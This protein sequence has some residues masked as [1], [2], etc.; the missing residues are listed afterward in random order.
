MR[1]LL[2]TN[3]L[4]QWGA[5]YC[6]DRG[7]DDTEGPLSPA[8]SPSEGERE[9]RSRFASVVHARD[10]SVKCRADDYV[11][12]ESASKLDALHT[13]RAVQERSNLAPAFGVRGACS[14]FRH[15]LR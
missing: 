14:R 3:V 8:L 4:I 11:R 9:K 10:S 12:G 5:I 13:L 6:G 7:I 2:D 1:W 15:Q